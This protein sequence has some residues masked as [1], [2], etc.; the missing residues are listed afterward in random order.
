MA[1]VSQLHASAMASAIKA[2]ARELGFDQVGI[3]SADPSQFAQYV[4]QW[5]AD[6]KHGEMSY[7]AKRL[8][9]RIDPQQYFPGAKSVICAAINYHTPLTPVLENERERHGR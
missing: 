5:I 2:R 8:E 3:A 1:I 7:L 4:R 9:E 6:G